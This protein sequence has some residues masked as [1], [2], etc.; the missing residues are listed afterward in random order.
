M[1][2]E[3]LLKPCPFCGSQTVELYWEEDYEYENGGGISI[4]YVVECEECL[5]RSGSFTSTKSKTLAKEGAAKAWN[6]RVFKE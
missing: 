1:S 4:T 6:Q 5:A 3:I 2:K